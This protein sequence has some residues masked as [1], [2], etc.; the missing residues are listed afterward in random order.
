[1]YRTSNSTVIDAWE[2]ISINV[3]TILGMYGSK[4]L[5]QLRILLL[6]REI[7]SII[8]LMSIG[9]ANENKT[10]LQ[11]SSTRVMLLIFIS[12]TGRDKY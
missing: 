8:F 10:L 4:I 9:R 1:M 2:C 5:S 7:V 12:T 3:I 6:M 11:L